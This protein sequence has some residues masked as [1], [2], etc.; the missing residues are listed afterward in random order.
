MCYWLVV[1][2]TFKL[3]SGINEL[4][5]LLSKQRQKVL[6]SS[7]SKTQMNSD[8]FLGHCNEINYLFLINSLSK[9]ACG[10]AGTPL[11]RYGLEVIQESL[12][13][14]AK[15]SWMLSEASVRESQPA[16]PVTLMS[17]RRSRV[18]ASLPQTY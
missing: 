9:S 10:Q 6:H 17:L 12:L 16:S 2:L 13:Q 11:F 14:E 15:Q 4:W 1:F 8:N 5:Q 3:A 7:V 18:G